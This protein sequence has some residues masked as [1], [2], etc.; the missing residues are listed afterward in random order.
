VIT[1]R[2]RTAL[3]SIVDMDVLRGSELAEFQK[4][5]PSVVGSLK[6]A[7]L[8]VGSAKRGYS[9]STAGLQALR[10]GRVAGDERVVQTIAGPMRIGGRG[11]QTPR[12]ANAR[13]QATGDGE[14]V[15]SVKDKD[16]KILSAVFY[17]RHDAISIR[18]A[19]NEMTLT[20]ARKAM[21]G[22]N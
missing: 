15:L 14:W 21:K 11:G 22:L 19:L 12:S 4:V 8:I 1:Q 20:D 16:S 7:G 13:V 10:S 3:L 17:H 5:F 9:V 6:K 18:D 2:Q